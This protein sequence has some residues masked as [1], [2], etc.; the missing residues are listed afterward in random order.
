MN[1]TN[2]K[3]LNLTKLLKAAKEAKINSPGTFTK[4]EA[5]KLKLGLPKAKHIEIDAQTILMKSEEKEK[6]LEAINRDISE[7]MNELNDLGRNEKREQLRAL[8]IMI[9]GSEAEMDSGRA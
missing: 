6:L 1:G 7:L 9:Q 5:D 3:K 4:E 2:K 8:R